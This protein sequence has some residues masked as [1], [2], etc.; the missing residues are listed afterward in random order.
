MIDRFLAGELRQRLGFYPGVVLLGPRQVGKTTLARQIASEHRGAVVLDLERP[1]DRARLGEP[2]I[3]FARLRDRL[4]VLDEVQNMPEIFSVLRP[5]I[6]AARNPGRFLLLGSA[7]GKLLMQSSQSLA[8]RVG[9][10]ELTPFRV[11]EVPADLEGL[12]KLWLRGGFPLSYTA[13][14]DAQSYIW[15]D[16]FI[17]SFLQRD[18]PQLGVG[19]PPETLYRFWR[20]LAHLHGQLFNASQIGGALGG[21]THTSVARYLDIMIDTMMVRRLE[22]HFV[23]IGKRLIK[24]PK[25]YL[26]DSGLLHELLGVPD[27]GALMAHPKGAR[28]GK[29]LRSKTRSGWPS[30][31]KLTSGGHIRG[32]SSTCCSSRT[33]GGWGSNSSGRMRLHSRRP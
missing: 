32:R 20:M 24:A 15:R 14:D 2:S 31:T 29:G 30:Q 23:N 1:S 27:H 26:R 28:R 16:D 11:G 10:L 9:Y 5:E 13:P 3:F 22:P 8:G 21:V 4:V 7:S 17:G 25:I 19:V 18:L 33:D 12:Q 6:D